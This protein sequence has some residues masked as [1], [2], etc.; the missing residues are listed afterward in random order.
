MLYSSRITTLLGLTY[1]CSPTSSRAKCPQVPTTPSTEWALYLPL[2]CPPPFPGVLYSQE[3]HEAVR[4]EIEQLDVFVEGLEKERDRVRSERD[5]Y[6]AD[7]AA[8]E[9]EYS[10]ALKEC[11]RDILATPP[12]PSRLTWY[13]FGAASGVLLTFSA[14]LALN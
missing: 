14:W 4:L 3:A 7:L 12:P 8:R 1:L 13:L 5:D 2:E 11:E 6:A 9:L 10:S